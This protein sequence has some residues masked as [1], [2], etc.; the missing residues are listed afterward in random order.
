M[1]RLW[2]HLFSKGGVYDPRETGFQELM[3]HKSV[4]MTVRYSDLTLKHTLAAVVI[5]AGPITATTTDTRTSTK[6][7]AQIS[8]EVS[9]IH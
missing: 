1:Q 8:H 9:N 6:P 4:Q 7:E 2:Y 5:L 3:D